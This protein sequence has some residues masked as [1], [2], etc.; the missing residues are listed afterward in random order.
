MIKDTQDLRKLA[1]YRQ[2]VSNNRLVLPE[3]I[4]ELESYRV[5]EKPIYELLIDDL[6]T[7]SWTIDELSRRYGIAKED[8]REPLMIA[9][10]D[11]VFVAEGFVPRRVGRVK[12][13]GKGRNVQYA[14]LPIP[15][16]ARIFDVTLGLS[17]LHF[18]SLL[19]QHVDQ[20]QFLPHTE[21]LDAFRETVAECWDI[22]EDKIDQFISKQDVNCILSALGPLFI[23]NDGGI[24]DR[25]RNKLFEE[26]KLLV[27]RFT[28]KK[29]NK[30]IKKIRRKFSEGFFDFTDV[31]STVIA[32]SDLTRFCKYSNR[33]SEH[34]ELLK[35]SEDFFYSLFIQVHETVPVPA[36]DAD[37]LTNDISEVSIGAGQSGTQ[38]KEGTTAMSWEAPKCPVDGTIAG[39]YTVITSETAKITE[40]QNALRCLRKHL[41]APGAFD[42]AVYCL[43]TSKNTNI[44]K[45][46][47]KL[48]AHLRD[49][50]AVEPL[51]TAYGQVGVILSVEV[52]RALGSI[53]SHEAV[54]LLLEVLNQKRFENRIAAIKALGQIRDPR[55]VPPLI[56][57]LLEPKSEI[58]RYATIALGDIGDTAAGPALINLLYNSTS[59]V[60]IEAIRAL[61]K[62]EYNQAIP[63]LRQLR[64]DRSRAVRDEVEKSLELLSVT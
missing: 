13:N 32:L 16:E 3:Q 49:E 24:Y 52:I 31:H 46:A 54:P 64:D 48:L 19:I 14:L 44:Q 56:Q 28:R 36:S 58:Q 45:E 42:L 34:A 59:V 43:T 18:D 30:D 17:L 63:V 27:P 15:I 33:M 53:G 50:R 61:V 51:I 7:S 8:I 55:A 35:I 40:K 20:L 6:K 11:P 4:S 41:H 26:E 60:R 21:G 9:M 39:F 10:R 37:A 12:R 25:I 29:I 5:L 22:R 1:Y 57:Y 23:P 62:L 47:I 2:L 38:D